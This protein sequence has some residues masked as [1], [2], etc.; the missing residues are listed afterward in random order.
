[1]GLE[2]R[3]RI[4]NKIQVLL[5]DVWCVGNTSECNGA[6]A[7]GRL[8]S[9]LQDTGVSKS[10]AG[11]CS[12]RSQTHGP[13]LELATVNVRELTSLRIFTNQECATRGVSVR[14]NEKARGCQAPAR[15]QAAS[16]PAHVWVSQRLPEQD[17]T[18]S[19]PFDLVNDLGPLTLGRCQL[20]SANTSGV[21]ELIS[22]IVKSLFRCLG[23][24]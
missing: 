20:T 9:M 16:P 3:T 18:N 8:P 5:H 6:T 1:M 21:H 17:F 13:V 12:T 24:V 10:G 15:S 19:L 22:A 11:I 23:F 7:Q 14:T 4:K 2:S